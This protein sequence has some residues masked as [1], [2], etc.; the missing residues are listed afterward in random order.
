MSKKAQ[1]RREARLTQQ[2]GAHLQRLTHLIRSE[3]VATPEQAIAMGEMHAA[4]E[5]LSEGRTAA[6]AVEVGRNAMEYLTGESTHLRTLQPFPVACQ[7]GCAWCCHLPVALTAPEALVIAEY[8]RQTLTPEALSTVTKR[9][10]TQ[11]Q[12][13]AALSTNAHAEVRMP[14]ALL[15]DRLCSVY[16]VRPLRCRGWTSSDA[17]TCE[18]ALS[19]PWDLT[20]Q[21][22]RALFL[23]G[24]A[25]TEG[26]K[27]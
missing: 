27:A 12:Q 13:A 9:L 5:I 7:A 26:L 2:A 8:L 1:R 17:S 22:D 14:C 25:V 11:A 24:H 4:L 6:K 20:V 21:V 15:Q 18:A 10:A 23:F 19:Q 16:K 3:H